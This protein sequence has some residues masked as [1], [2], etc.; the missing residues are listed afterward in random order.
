[1]LKRLLRLIDSLPHNKAQNVRLFGLTPRQ[2]IRN[3]NWTRR[4]V[5]REISSFEYLMHL[6]TAAGRTCVYALPAFFFFGGVFL[7][8]LLLLACLLAC[9]FFFLLFSFFSFFFFL[10]FLFLSSCLCVCAVVVSMLL[11]CVCRGNAAF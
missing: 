6:N 11:A 3:G 7:L 8:L 2:L 10:F 9:I 4:W 1:M 5:N